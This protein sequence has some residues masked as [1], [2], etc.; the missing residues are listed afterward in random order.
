M[1]QETPQLNVDAVILDDD[2]QVCEAM[3]GLFRQFY[4]WGEVHAFSDFAEALDYCREL[5]SQTAVFVLDVYLN[6]PTAFD[7]LEA[8]SDQYPMAT[9]DSIIITGKADDEVVEKCIEAKVNHLLEKP[10]RTY[11]FQFAVRAILSKYQRFAPRLLNDPEYAA[12]LVPL[13]VEA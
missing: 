13:D 6:G 2:P 10:V 1:P 11:A 3:E 5:D 7:F 12:S 9:D 4:T 8:I